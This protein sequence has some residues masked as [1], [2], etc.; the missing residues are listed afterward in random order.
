LAA[1]A[2][3]FAT[4]WAVSYTWPR[5]APFREFA[6]MYLREIAGPVA[7][8][9]LL[10]GAMDRYVPKEYISRLLTG[11]KKRTIL[12]AVLLGT[13]MSACSHGILALAIQ[14]YRKGASVPVVIAFLLASPWANLPITLLLFGLFGAKAFFVL[15]G[16]LMVAT[17]T[18]VLYQGLERRGWVEANPQ[19]F[20]VAEGFSVTGDLRR[21]FQEY[22]PTPGR[23]RAD[24]LAILK[25]STALGA[26]TLPW[27]FVGVAFSGLAATFVPAEFFRRYMGPTPGGM[28]ATLGLATVV[29][30]CSE[31][32]APFA[33]ELYRQ[34]LAF[35]NAFIFLMAGVV[36]DYTEISLLWGNVGRRAALWLPAIA[37]PQ[38]MVLGAIANAL[39]R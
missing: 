19:T 15:G 4:L 5:L 32:T 37:V 33:F 12:S 36:T 26:M 8:G 2:A 10:G 22:R 21:R 3:A 11:Q 30:V 24:A 38:V 29:E 23:L 17:T 14:L 28:A 18:G 27:I 1:A 20:S 16:A 6:G 31:G 13:L 9:L 34:T 35:G 39:F 25:G 7:L